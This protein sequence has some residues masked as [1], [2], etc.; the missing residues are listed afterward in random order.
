MRDIPSAVKLNK[1]G[2]WLSGGS[3]DSVFTIDVFS[4]T[5]SSMFGMRN[6]SKY[7]WQSASAALSRASG[8]YSRSFVIMSM[9]SGVV[10][11]SKT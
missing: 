4:R 1:G 6:S 9:A 8:V 11:G 3:F 7:G 10:S 2:A 5:I